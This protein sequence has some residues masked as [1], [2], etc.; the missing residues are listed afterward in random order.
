MPGW[1]GPPTSRCACRGSA[2]QLQ[3]GYRC[4]QVAT[5]AGRK[6]RA[7]AHSGRLHQR[8]DVAGRRGGGRRWGR[9]QPAPRRPNARGAPGA[10]GRAGRRLHLRRAD[11]QLPGGQRHQ[12][13][14]A[15]RRAGRR[16][17][18][19][20]GRRRSACPWCCSSRAC[21]S[22][23]AASRALG[24]NIIN[25]ALVTAF[26]GYAVFLLLRQVL[27]GDH[28]ASVRRGRRRRRRLGGAGVAR[29]H[30]RVRHRR[31]R[32]GLGRHGR[33]AAMVGVHM[34]IGIGEGIIT[35]LTVGA[36]LACA[37]TSST[38]PATSGAAGLGPTPA[39]TA[40]GGELTA[41]ARQPSACSSPAACWS[42]RC[43][44]FFV[45]PYASSQP[46]GLNKVATDKGFAADARAAT[47][48][49]RPAGRLRASRA[50]TTSG[51][52]T[53]LAGIIGVAVTFAHRRRRCSLGSGP[54]GVRRPTAAG[55]ADVER[56]LTRGRPATRHLLYVHGHEPAAPA[57]A[58]SASSPPR[59]CSCSPSSPRR[60]RRSGRSALY[61]VVLAAGRH[62]RPACRSPSLAR[63]LVIE[64]PFLLFAVFLPFVGQG[65]RVDVLGLRRCRSP[66]CG[67]AWNI[68]VKGTL[69]V[70]ASAS[71]W[72]PPP[73]CPSCCAASTASGCRRC[74][75]RS[76]GS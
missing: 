45:S 11:A 34:L 25:M 5:G 35:A 50:S 37:P 4:N 33:S 48:R 58:R 75:P 23:T 55:P 76:P 46:D 38:A 30:R 3:A 2:L 27:P 56:P 21:C 28:D 20:V 31:Q 67:A 74:S 51:L 17:R 65:E 53:G 69:G 66:A 15:R 47:C 73:R 49:R 43:W 10:A 68:V 8:P 9:G 18:R 26:G 19:A 59:C 6:G 16:A 24:L 22:P 40:R 29:V 64:L 44:P 42:P 54:C 41:C 72:P 61:A 13:P 12:R 39:V 52:S 57:R 60:A 36:V 7:R 32:R 1:A 62:R 71:C 70:A 63:R 14:P